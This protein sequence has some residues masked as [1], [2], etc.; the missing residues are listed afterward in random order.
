VRRGV[1]AIRPRGAEQTL[2]ANVLA[3]LALA[4]GM[5]GS[6]KLWGEHPG[7]DLAVLI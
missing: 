2:H 1:L 6:G 3:D 5:E 7:A 4:V